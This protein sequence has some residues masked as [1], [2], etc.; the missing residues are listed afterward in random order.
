VIV[1]AAGRTEI[2]AMVVFADGSPRLMGPPPHPDNTIV[3][4]RIRKSGN[5][6]K[7]LARPAGRE[8]VTWFST[9]GLSTE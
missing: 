4:I 8:T 7:E 1:L 5:G 3:A 6:K 2:A 9:D